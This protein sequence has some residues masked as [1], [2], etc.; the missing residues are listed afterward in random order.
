MA[1][2]RHTCMSAFMDVSNSSHERPQGFVEISAQTTRIF[3]SWLA[4]RAEPNDGQ[5]CFVTLTRCLH[6]MFTELNSFL[7][8]SFFVYYSS[9]IVE[10]LFSS[11]NKV[12]FMTST[13][14]L[15]CWISRK[16]YEDLPC[17]PLYFGN[18]LFIYLFFFGDAHAK[19][20]R[21]GVRFGEGAPRASVKFRCQIASLKAK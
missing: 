2:Y 12:R 20:L 3:M 6:S 19:L 17:P 9:W 4:L 18:F 21:R 16:P 14:T 1:T 10:N 8:L 5:C 11:S 15:S 13:I 7:F